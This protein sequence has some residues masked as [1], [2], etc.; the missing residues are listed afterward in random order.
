ML[1]YSEVL[2]LNSMTCVDSQWIWLSIHSIK[3]FNWLHYYKCSN[4]LG[5]CRYHHL[6]VFWLFNK[7]CLQYSLLMV[8]NT[9]SLEE[10]WVWGLLPA[11]NICLWKFALDRQCSIVLKT[12]CFFPTSCRIYS[13]T[14]ALDLMTNFQLARILWDNSFRYMRPRFLKMPLLWTMAKYKMSFADSSTHSLF[15][16]WESS[17]LENVL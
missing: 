13:E 11:R 14:W 16:N 8:T 6:R 7:A 15:L 2:L 1:N 3:H 17:F 12:S 9:V 5:Q 10:V 4:F